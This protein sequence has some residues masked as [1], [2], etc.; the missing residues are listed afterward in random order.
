MICINVRVEVF[1]DTFSLYVGTNLLLTVA[2]SQGLA[3][4]EP[5]N[6]YTVIGKFLHPLMTEK[7]ICLIWYLNKKMVI[8]AAFHRR[9]IITI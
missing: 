1:T 6:Y 2:D 7:L 3:G 5:P 8:Q 4:G 9:L